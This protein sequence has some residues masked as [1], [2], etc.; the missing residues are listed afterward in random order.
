MSKPCKI[1]SATL[2]RARAAAAKAQSADEL[3]CAQAILLPAV[4]GITWKKTA[5]LLGVGRSTIPRLQARFRQ[6]S[7]PGK[8]ARR[9]W[10]GRRRALLTLSEEKVF[11][12]PWV[13]QAVEGRM[14]VVSSL[15]AAFAQNLGR[16][17]AATVVYRMLERHGWRKV[18]PATRHPKA[19]P[20]AQEDWKKNSRKFW[21]ISSMPNR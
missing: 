3:R 1:D 10:G 8:V 5:A 21:R 15:R 19:D 16:P 12:A 18:A 2:K 6:E 11:L 4:T 14:L 17:V 20:K 7:A 13:A 9:N